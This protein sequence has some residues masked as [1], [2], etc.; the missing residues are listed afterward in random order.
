MVRG[1]CVGR[2]DSELG[3]CLEADV[4]IED[5]KI[6]AIG[7]ALQRE[8]A[9]IVEA[10]GKILMP[11][12]IDGHRHV[13]EGIDA[14]RLVKTHLGG[15]GGFST[16]QDWKQRAIVSSTPEDHYLAGLIGGLQAIDSGVTSVVDYAHGQHTLDNALGAARGFKDSGVGGWFAIAP[17]VSS[18]YKPGD[19]L[20]LVQ[21]QYERHT[22]FK[23]WQWAITETLQAEDFA[24]RSA[25]LQLAIC[26]DTDMEDPLP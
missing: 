14:G 11:G 20:P 13:W 6:A 3:E 23:D 18:S 7:K 12:M 16:Y 22:P 15:A 2:R 8:G 19:T 21:A 10:R 26:P 9:E 4:L 24:D 5:G 17:Y 1:A 25:P